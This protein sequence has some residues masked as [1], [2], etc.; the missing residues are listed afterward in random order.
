MPWAY[1]LNFA[2]NDYLYELNRFGGVA[3]NVLNKVYDGVFDEK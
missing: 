2:L 1:A 3:Y